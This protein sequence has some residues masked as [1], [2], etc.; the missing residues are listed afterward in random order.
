MKGSLTAATR[1]VKGKGGLAS[2]T[3]RGRLMVFPNRSCD[4]RIPFFKP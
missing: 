4:T 3:D 1:V 2:L